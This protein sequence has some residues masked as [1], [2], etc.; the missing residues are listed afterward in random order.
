MTATP[1][2]PD[3]LAAALRAGRRAPADGIHR[4]VDAVLAGDVDL[5]AFGRWLVALADAG[6]T[7]AEIA[8]VAAA[9]R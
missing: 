6:E 7:A 3:T 8:G 1:P 9:L 2:D 4:L 5:E